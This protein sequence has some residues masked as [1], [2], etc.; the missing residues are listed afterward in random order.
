[1]SRQDRR[2]KPGKDIAAM[3]LEEFDRI[4]ALLRL[5][6]AK[7]TPIVIGKMNPRSLKDASAFDRAMGEFIASQESLPHDGLKNAELA[8][9]GVAWYRH[10]KWRHPQPEF[11]PPTFFEKE[12]PLHREAAVTVARC[13]EENRQ[14]V[15]SKNFTVHD[16]KD[17]EDVDD[18]L[19]HAILEEEGCPDSVTELSIQRPSAFANLASSYRFREDLVE[20]TRDLFRSGKHKT[21][22]G[23]YTEAFRRI[24]PNADRMIADMQRKAMGEQIAASRGGVNLQ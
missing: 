4:T 17:P 19:K 5:K 9:K 3:K 15:M 21:K 8:A 2:L 7:Y 1:M 23:G 20:V 13:I 18:R 14:D 24:V 11:P 16:F 12:D 10:A 6:V 22:D